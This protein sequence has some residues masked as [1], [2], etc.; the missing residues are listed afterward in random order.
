[1]H[2]RDDL[3]HIHHQGFS[4]FA[5]SAAPGVLALLARQGLRG[6]HVVEIGCG[7]GILA[8]ELTRAGSTVTG[9]DLSQ[10]MIE[11]ARTTAPGVSFSV[12]SFDTVAIPPC[13]AV[14]AMGEVLNHGTFAGVR[15]FVAHAA[16][17]L[18]PGGLLLFDVAERSP[19][20][21]REETRLG[22]DDWSVIAINESDGRTLRRRVLTFRRIGEEIRRDEER[23]DLELYDRGEV[24]SLLREHAFRV[25]VRR[26]YGTIR[27]PKGHAVYMALTP[28]TGAPKKPQH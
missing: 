23:H 7:T 18:R 15:T 16:E 12:G 14:V 22:G 10:S 28:G 6:G 21:A 27:L 17:A 13:D 19:V 25:Q 1:M 3:T 4:E 9:V 26:S 20:A 8:R 11:L 5:E 24:L 2:Y